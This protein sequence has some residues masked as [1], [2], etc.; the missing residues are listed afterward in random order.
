MKDQLRTDLEGS[1]TFLV[2]LLFDELEHDRELSDECKTHL[3]NLTRIH[4][5]MATQVDVE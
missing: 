1:I 2:K 4:S 5:L 3:R